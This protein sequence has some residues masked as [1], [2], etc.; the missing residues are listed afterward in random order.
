MVPSSTLNISKD[1]IYKE[2]V[3][4]V[5]PYNIILSDRIRRMKDKVFTRNKEK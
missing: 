1:L 3:K 2:K 5:C 4:I